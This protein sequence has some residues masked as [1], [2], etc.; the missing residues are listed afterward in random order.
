MG[1]CAWNPG[2][3][4]WPVSAQFACALV[5]QRKCGGSSPYIMCGIFS[6][7]GANRV[8]KNCMQVC[9]GFCAVRGNNG[10]KRAVRFGF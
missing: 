3:V 9:I 1:L 10:R 4:F 2:T 7:R 8:G 5:I 6:V